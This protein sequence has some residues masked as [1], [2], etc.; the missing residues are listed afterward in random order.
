[1]PEIGFVG[2]TYVAA[3]IYHD[4]QEC[5]N[6][7]AE[8]GMFRNAKGIPERGVVALLPTPGLQT[9]VQ[10]PQV[11]E[12]R[13]LYTATGG[14]ILYAAVGNALCTVNPAFQANV[15]GTLNTSSGPVSIIDNGSS[16]MIADG[17]NRYTCALSGA[18]FSVDASGAFPGGTRIDEVDNFIVYNNPNT[19]KL[20]QN[21]SYTVEADDL[22][23]FIKELDQLLAGRVS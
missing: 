22:A 3:S 23:A 16:V 2:P 17:V 4:D 7:Y 5:I 11:A 13:G 21:Y 18:G 6:W 15:I 1:M 8:M 20:H 9:Q 10:L 14:N 12:V 19:N